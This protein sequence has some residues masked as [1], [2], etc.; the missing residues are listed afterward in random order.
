MWTQDDRDKA[1]A[2]SRRL[3]E[4]CPNCQTYEEDWVDENGRLLD[5]PKYTAWDR[6]CHGCG[7][8]TKLRD[9][10]PEG[11]RGVYVGLVPFDSVD[12]EAWAEREQSRWEVD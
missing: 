2:F 11:Q 5:P 10:L 3:S 1:V 9:T 8:I 12:W 7:E 6:R 4:R